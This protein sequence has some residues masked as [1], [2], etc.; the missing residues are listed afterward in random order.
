MNN[1][2]ISKQ[3]P[4]NTPYL[5]LKKNTNS[6]CK[7]ILRQRFNPLEPNLVW[8]SDVTEIKIKSKPVYLCIIMDL[9]ARKIIGHSI[10]L[11]NNTK[12]VEKTFNHALSNR[13]DKL[14]VMFH[15]DRG[16][17]YTSYQFRQTIQRY[18]ITQSFSAPGYPYDNS[19]ME[20]FFSQYKRETL[21]ERSSISTIKAYKEFV[22]EYIDYYN[23]YRF[24]RGL[25]LL[26]PNK[27]EE[28]YQD[29]HVRK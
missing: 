1:L 10:S 27:K 7:N 15:S 20:S 18:N 16:S 11:K 22:Q 6:T 23:A 17:P 13:K 3:T 2:H 21:Q 9:F 19:P 26:T 12:L 14:P 4:K 25:G 28:L 29:S 5:K 8:V 24:H